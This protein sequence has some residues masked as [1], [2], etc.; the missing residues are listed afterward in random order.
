MNSSLG[1]QLYS[2]HGPSLSPRLSKM[3]CH[4]LSCNWES[5]GSCRDRGMRPPSPRGACRAPRAN[6]TPSFPSSI[7]FF[8]SLSFRCLRSKPVKTSKNSSSACHYSPEN[9]PKTETQLSWIYETRQE[10][11]VLFLAPSHTEMVNAGEGHRHGTRT[12]QP[13]PQDNTRLRL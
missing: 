7:S 9:E 4:V 5:R 10:R 3:I 11:S 1:A 13:Q 8:C 2:Q 12:F 6:K